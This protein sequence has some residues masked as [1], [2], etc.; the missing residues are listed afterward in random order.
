MRRVTKL[1]TDWEYTHLSRVEKTP[2]TLE[3]DE[4]IPIALPH[5][6]NLNNPQER[7][8]ALYQRV[9]TA[10]KKENESYYIAFDA[11]AGV[12]RVFLNG[13]FIGEHRG[14]YSRFCYCIDDAF[15]DGFNLLQVLA[16]NTKYQDVCPLVGDFTVWGGIYRDVSLIEVPEIHFDPT[17]YG[18]PGLD[19]TAHSDGRIEVS[20]RVKNAQGATVRYFV[21]DSEK[22]V[23]A[24]AEATAENPYSVLYVRNPHHW[25]GQDDPYLY[26]CTAELWKDG[27]LCDCESLDAGFR[28]I[29]LDAKR[30]FFLN[31][32]HLKLHGV[33]KHQDR[34]GKGCAASEADQREDMRLIEEIGANAVRLS[35]YQHPQYTYDLCDQMGFV[36]WAEIPMLAMPD[37]NIGVV[38]NAKSQMT[39]LILQNK[40]HPSICFWGVQNEIAMLGESQFSYEKVAELDA[41]VKD[42]DPTRFSAAANLYSVKNSSRLNFLNDAVGYNVYFGWYYGKMEDYDGFL[43][44]FHED[45]PSVPL[46]ITEYGV[47]CNLRYHTETP[48]CKDYTEEFQCLFHE[49]AYKAIENDAALWGSFIWNMFD[50]SSAVRDEGGIKARNCKGLITYDRQTRKDSFY[51]Y[52]ACWSQEPFVYL[53]GRRY[54]NRAA[55]ETTVVVYSNQTEVTLLVDGEIFEV[56]HG[57]R[58]FVFEGVPLK[59]KTIIIA[60]SGNL[61]DQMILHKVEVPDSTYVYPKRN[62]GQKV[63]NWFLTDAGAQNLSQEGVFSLNDKIGELLA[64]PDVYRVLEELLPEV[65]HDERAKMFGGMSLLRVL[66]RGGEEYSPELLTQVNSG[67]GKI[68]K[69][70]L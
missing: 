47:D 21:E 54:R 55:K 42:L 41:L 4:F 20:A 44:S 9:F 31:G 28:N 58:K 56:R 10:Q 64:N 14:G 70:E 26:R 3:Q 23:V 35:H 30:G 66:D 2:P 38:E 15:R 39:E 27:D 62:D 7:G 29:R 1:M 5:I 69:Q 25:N 24:E 33:A 67:L 48:E 53:T 59:E 36:A 65:A 6:W 63:T 46:A 37:G 32:S 52:K 68:S 49:N 17:Y 61:Q 18:A 57:N 40:H 43:A 34:E 13:Q 12:A 60:V 16:D 8:C 11:V 50:F 51:Y 22:N 19:L 45:N